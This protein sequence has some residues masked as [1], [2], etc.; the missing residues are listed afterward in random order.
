VHQSASGEEDQKGRDP[1]LPDTQ[2]ARGDEELMRAVQAGDLSAFEQI[3]LRHQAAVW[4]TAGRLLNDP[5][6][7]EDVAQEAFLRVLDAAPRYRPAAKFRT[8]LLQIVARLCLDRLRKKRP[9]YTEN[10]PE[11]PADSQPPDGL[12]IGAEQRRIMRQALEQ[13]PAR[14][15]LALILRYDQE[16]SY[17]EIAA[18][19]QVSTK[20]V[21]RLLARG[22]AGLAAVLSAKSQDDYDGEGVF[23]RLRV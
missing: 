13:L 8:Y 19:L 2:P 12:L 16:L 17:Q 22:R 4:N 18:V 10:L 3:I 14:R 7:A 6:E 11:Q 1:N 21:E 5:A 15:R 23:R 9:L 20:A